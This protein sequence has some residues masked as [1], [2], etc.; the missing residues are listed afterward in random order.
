MAR[1][2]PHAP[3]A[4][5]YN[6]VPVPE[7]SDSTESAAEHPEPVTPTSDSTSPP[8]FDK[9]NAFVD[10]ASDPQMATATM[11][12]SGP[13]P[14]RP[15]ATTTDTVPRGGF[16]KIG[17]FV[18]KRI[19]RTNSSKKGDDSTSSSENTLDATTRG[20]TTRRVAPS[21]DTKTNKANPPSPQ[22]DYAVISGWSESR[23]DSNHSSHSLSPPSPTSPA[24][25]L[26]DGMTSFDFGPRPFHTQT[27][28]GANGL[29]NGITFDDYVTK[30]GMVER[31]DHLLNKSASVESL[32][33]TVSHQ[34]PMD[35]VPAS[36][37]F[38]GR[39][40]EGTGLKSRRLSTILPDEFNVD[41]CELDK[42]FKSTSA[43]PFRRGRKLGDGATA[44]VRIMCR[45]DG[46]VKE[47]LFAAKQFRTK[48]RDEFEGEY[49]KKI[50][51][52]FS[53]SK[54]LHHPNIVESI[55]LCTHN[56]RWSHIME[57]CPHGELY[58]LVK[59][60]LFLPPQFGGHYRAADRLC[61][62]KQICRGV[63]YLH[64]H[65]IAHR[66]LK[67]ENL[68]IDSEGHLKISDFGVSEVF[69][70]EHPGLRA[71][72]GECGVNMGE[73]RL[74]KPG[75]C[76]SP[77]YIAPEVLDKRCP[78]D[79]RAVDV[80]ST[81]ICLFFMSNQSPWATADPKNDVKYAAYVR[82]WDEWLQ[83]HPDGR[84]LDDNS[85]DAYPKTSPSFQHLDNPSIKKL[86]VK[87]LHPDPSKRITMRELLATPT[88]RAIE[89]C[90][91][92]GYDDPS[93]TISVDA[94]TK[95]GCK[96]ARKALTVKKHHHLPPKES[97]IPKALQ[98][99]FDMGHGWS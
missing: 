67:L 43:I 86:V 42:E 98:H 16:K 40:A 75:I 17:T 91:P 9:P 11:T 68:L 38:L 95:A 54:S 77:P 25:T 24:S 7:D 48:D 83:R 99:R 51:S 14:V 44:E 61:F 65:G 10:K 27:H 49:L 15:R 82:N 2:V 76:G 87:M 32:P 73:I 33:E 20:P 69:S 74:C 56:G 23:K 53:I 88:M 96:N 92:E 37:P 63:G 28:T 6:S 57:F 64:D 39:A 66:D 30:Q 59:K 71:A 89:C 5:E 60:G 8:T 70:G 3:A 47:G 62:F 19:H 94:R 46:G 13:R 18:K 41:Y 97:K 22:A 58:A 1:P 72:R 31:R 85:P 21:A 29:R 34:Q 45:K 78:Y 12:L 84:V 93:S 90:T 80:W 26:D 81:A 55:R 79:P 36:R 52:E 35:N 4:T 50:K